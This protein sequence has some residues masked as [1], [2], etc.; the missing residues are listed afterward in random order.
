MIVLFLFGVG[1]FAIGTLMLMRPMAF[2]NGIAAFSRKRWFHGVEITSRLL[3]GVLFIVFASHS[4][5]PW[6][7]AGLGGLL[8]FVSVFLIMIGEQ[9]HR[10][11]A[12][13]TARIGHGFRPLGVIAQLCGAVFVYVSLPLAG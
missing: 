10:R 8:C 12:L 7:L 1:M 2:A 3:V 4:R 6:L 11:F 5:Y 9:R 13:R